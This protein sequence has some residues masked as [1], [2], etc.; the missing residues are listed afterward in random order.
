MFYGKGVLKN[1]GKSLFNKVSSPKK[2]LK[3]T[4][5]QNTSGRVIVRNLILLVF[6]F[7]KTVKVCI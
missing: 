4:F 1:S 5:L 3:E 2:F 7:Q 6:Y